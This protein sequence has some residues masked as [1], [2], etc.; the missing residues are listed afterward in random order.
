MAVRV[1]QVKF[2]LQKKSGNKRFIFNTKNFFLSI[3]ARVVSTCIQKGVTMLTR[4]HTSTAQHTHEGLV[5]GSHL[6]ILLMVK[7]DEVTPVRIHFDR[8]KIYIL[9]PLLLALPRLVSNHKDGINTTLS[10]STKRGSH[11]Y[12]SLSFSVYCKL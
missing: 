11:V 9:T 12:R 1:K 2:L 6:Q 8:V 7:N 3:K 10:S 5:Q 4:T